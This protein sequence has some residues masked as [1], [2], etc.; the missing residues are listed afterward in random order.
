MVGLQLL[1]FKS[2]DDRESVVEGD[3]VYFGCIDP[4]VTTTFL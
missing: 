3:S 4:Q 2:V 1:P